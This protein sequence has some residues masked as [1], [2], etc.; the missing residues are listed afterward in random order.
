MIRARQYGSL[1]GAK[2]YHLYP[3]DVDVVSVDDD[4]FLP[5]SLEEVKKILRVKTD[6]DND[7]ITL[8]IK[9]VTDQV[10][11]HIGRDLQPKVRLAYWSAP[12]ITIKPTFPPISFIEEVTSVDEDGN[13]RVLN[14][15]EYRVEGLSF[16]KTI[17]LDKRHYNIL[18]QYACGYAQC[19]DAIKAA[20]HQEIALQY[21]RRN[22]PNTPDLVSING[23][24]I[25]ARHLL[26]GG[27]FYEYAR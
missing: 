6:S 27:G 1:T 10:E 12:A 24:S 4:N 19:P 7:F 23:L 14:E 8:L 17:H 25:E 26:V 3:S 11:R 13:V 9:G 20:I 18:V 22:D 15:S 2:T 5:V 16:D 21:K